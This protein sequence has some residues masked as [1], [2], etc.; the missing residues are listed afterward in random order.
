MP[1]VLTLELQQDIAANA[2][3]VWDV[4]SNIAEAPR[5]MSG[6]VATQILSKPEEGLLGLRWKE[7]R[8][9]YGNQ[10]DEILEI[11]E[12]VPK[13]SYTVVAFN[14]GT[15]YHSR[16]QVIPKDS[17]SILKMSFTATAKTL[18]AKIMSNVMWPL[19][20]KSMNTI[21]LQDLRD[22]KKQAEQLACH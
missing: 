9:L 16:M 12:V 7:T 18:S 15:R 17:F 19:I 5:Y 4:I 13:K 2:G 6:I 14:H 11:I 10:A 20:R 21:L 22:I 3:L 8:V 1:R